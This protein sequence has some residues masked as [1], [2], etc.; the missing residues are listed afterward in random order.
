MIESERTCGYNASCLLTSPARATNMSAQQVENCITT[1]MII[2]L[3]SHLEFN[4]M[5]GQ[6]D[7]TGLRL[8]N[9]ARSWWHSLSVPESR[10]SAVQ[11][12]LLITFYHERCNQSRSSSLFAST[13][14]RL[15]Q[16]LGS[17]RA[18]RF[19]LPHPQAEL[20]IALFW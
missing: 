7:S 2:A 12:S 4:Q 15:I 8:F 1:I 16:L 10:I 9:N 17:H 11:C 5:P 20:H 18:G 19:T 3:G 13:T 6:S 14:G